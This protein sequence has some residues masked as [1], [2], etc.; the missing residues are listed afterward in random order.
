MRRASFRPRPFDRSHYGR[1]FLA[2]RLTEAPVIEDEVD[3]APVPAPKPRPMPKRAR[4]PL[5][6]D[7]PVDPDKPLPGQPVPGPQEPPDPKPQDPPAKAAP[8]RARAK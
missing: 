2:T 6:D 8:K 7:E 4:V 3:G 5:T 1:S